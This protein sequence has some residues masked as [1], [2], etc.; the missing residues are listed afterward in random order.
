[1]LAQKAGSSSSTHSMD[2]TRRKEIPQRAID[3]LARRAEPSEST[4]SMTWARGRA[5]PEHA[6]GELAKGQCC[7]LGPARLPPGLAPP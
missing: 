7:R 4:H 5:V 6:I 3:E 2:W 1:M